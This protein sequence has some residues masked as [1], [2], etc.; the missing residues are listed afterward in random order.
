[1]CCILTAV[2]IRVN[3]LLIHES[4]ATFCCCL[5]ELSECVLR[6]KGNGAGSTSSE[7]FESP[8]KC[9]LIN[10]CHHAVQQ[11]LN[12]ALKVQLTN[13]QQV[14]PSNPD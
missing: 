3:Y 10:T 2:E 4:V 13:G 1:M 7:N 11:V 6:N 8:A 5:P 12:Y 14:A 9:A